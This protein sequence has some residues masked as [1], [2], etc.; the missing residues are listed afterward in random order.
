MTFWIPWAVN[1]VVESVLLFF[2]L[3]GLADDSVSS[4]N[5]GLWLLMLGVAAV[6]LGGSLA[7]KAA[8]RV[9][10]AKALVMVFAIP[11]VVLGLF[12]AVIV[13]VPGRW[14]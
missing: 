12:F 4:F 6:V 5:I 10:L 1:A 9:K 2:F 13:L 11:G 8:D 7:L 14:N 3:W